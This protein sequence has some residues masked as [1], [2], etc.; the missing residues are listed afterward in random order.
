MFRE[1]TYRVTA[2]NPARRDRCGRSESLPA[3]LDRQA[4]CADPK[5]FAQCAERIVDAFRRFTVHVLSGGC[6]Q[7]QYGA[8]L[9]D[10][11]T[12]AQVKDAFDEALLALQA[13]TPF[14]SKKARALRDACED[15]V[16][17]AFLSRLAC[18]EDQA[19][20]SAN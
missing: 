10:G 14:F 3:V 8:I 17:G 20:R 18:P 16:F 13:A 12:I 2:Q 4:P 15:S 1:E 9:Y 6:A 11:D 19:G 7:D 5:A